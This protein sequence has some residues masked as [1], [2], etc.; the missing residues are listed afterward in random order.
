MAQEPLVEPPWAGIDVVSARHRVEG[1]VVRTPLLRAPP[2]L[3]RTTTEVFLK[4]E[5]L[6]HGGSFKVRGATNRIATLSAEQRQRGIFTASSGNHAQGVA[7]AARRADVPATIVMAVGASPLKVRATQALGA[8]VVFHGEDY[9]DAFEHAVELGQREGLTFVHAYDDPEIIAGQATVGAEI[10][11]DLPNVR[12]VISGVGGGGLLSG[13]AS[14][15]RKA[16]SDAEVVGV[17]STG[18]STLQPS[19]HSGRLVEG[20]RPN[21]FA[22]GIATRHLGALPYR[23]LKAAGTRAIVVEDRLLARASFLLFERAKIVAEPAGASPLAAVLAH[24]ELLNEGPVVLVVSGGNL[25]PF[26][27][28]R[29]LLIGLAEDGRLLRLKV[30]LT[31]V[32]GRLAEFLQIA[33]ATRA[34]VRQVVQVRER[35]RQPVTEVV[36]EVELEVRDAA[37]AQELLQRYR[38]GGWNVEPVRLRDDEV[39]RSVS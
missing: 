37:H 13:I 32:P 22:D 11:E 19:L 10:L 1:E 39:T 20:A 4:L 35:P 27:L 29:V 25:D 38:A 5:N 30:A 9:D 36:V 6:Q 12:R 14:A 16:G 2:Q 7:W 28:E 23:I 26:L 31:D 3:V 15:L 18:A 21:T 24:P 33:A 17:Q 34:N 8:R